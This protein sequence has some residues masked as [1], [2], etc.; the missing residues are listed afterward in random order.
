MSVVNLVT[1]TVPNEKTGERGNFPR[2]RSWTWEGSIENRL[3]LL[4]RTANSVTG[5][6]VRRGGSPPRAIARL[7]TWN[8]TDGSCAR[9]LQIYRRRGSAGIIRISSLSWLDSAQFISLIARRKKHG[10]VSLSKGLHLQIFITGTYFDGK[11]IAIFLRLQSQ[12]FPAG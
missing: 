8:G 12:K 7:N 1:I 5:C 4:E 11:R 9:Y 10:D 3:G 2:D 6:Y